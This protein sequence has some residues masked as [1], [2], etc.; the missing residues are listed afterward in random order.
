NGTDVRMQWV[1]NVELNPGRESPVFVLQLA[2]GQ[3]GEDAVPVD[4]EGVVVQGQGDQTAALEVADFG[5]DDGT[6]QGRLSGV[7]VEGGLL[8]PP[9]RS[10]REKERGTGGD[11]PG[12][13]EGE[14]RGDR[15]ARYRLEVL[16]CGAHREFLRHFG[17]RLFESSQFL[18]SP[19]L[20]LLWTVRRCLP[21]PGRC[22][23]RFS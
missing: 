21:W 1:E 6:Q 17:Y 2:V 12:A 18:L 7:G 11:R 23:G 4:D 19:R 15:P 16:V 22:W 9:E 3:D 5:A 14:S 13:V 8:E 20:F 10:G